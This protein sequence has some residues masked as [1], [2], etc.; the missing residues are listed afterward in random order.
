MTTLVKKTKTSGL[1]ITAVAL[2]VFAAGCKKETPKEV[3]QETAPVA[4]KAVDLTQQGSDLFEQPIQPN[5]LERQPE[6]VVL[7]VNGVNI[8]H[9]EILQGVQMKISQ[10]GRRVPPQYLSQMQA[11]LYQNVSSN[12]VANILLTQ[13]AEKS[14]LAVSDEELAKEI[15]TIESNAPEGKTLKEAL[16]ENNIEYDEW[17]KNVRKQMVLQKLVKEKTADVA[18]ASVADI[19]QFYEENIDQ[20]KTPETVSASHIL[21]S[22]DTNDTSEVKAQKKAQIDQIRADLMAPEADFAAIAA[23]KSDCPS[24]QQGGSLGSFSRGQMVSEFENAAFTQ[25]IGVV[26][27][28]VETQFGYHLIK[29]TDRKAESVRSLNEV[30]EQLK[31][32]LTGKKKQEALVAYIEELKSKAEVVVHRPDFDAASDSE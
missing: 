29:V 18:E 2:S 11:Q 30:K 15:Q 25:E 8:T 21:I 4:E 27:E 9:G 13:A 19:T 12:L 7:S 1:L 16:A 17:T 14:G 23:E 20:F 5:P 28:V 32:Y 6:D 3:P 10:M 31:E 22:V 26:G 24:K